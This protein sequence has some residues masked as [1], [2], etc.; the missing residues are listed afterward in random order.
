MLVYRVG[1][2]KYISDLHG[3]GARLYGGR[4][5][6]KLTPCIY[7]SESRALAVLE[8]T[9]NT[10]IDNIPRA[11]SIMTLDI[12]I[13]TLFE[14]EIPKLPGNWQDNPAPDSTKNIGTLLLNHGMNAVIKVPSTVLK[15]EFN[16]I[17]NPLHE[18]AHLFKII[19]LED[20]IY[21]LRIKQND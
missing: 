20:F 4:W 12:P 2:T 17:L 7:T 11:L 1:S 19:A 21:D 9:V 10:N 8:Y 5:N 16:F 18:D 15:Q 14:L 6:H 13:S 3:E